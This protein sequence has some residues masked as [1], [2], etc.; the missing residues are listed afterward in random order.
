MTTP[1]RPVR[2]AAPLKRDGERALLRLR[3]DHPDRPII[4]IGDSHSD[5]G[6]M[7]LA[8]YAVMPTRSQAWALLQRDNPWIS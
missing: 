5:T 1:I 2:R 7:D 4:A 3:R 8:D 6:F